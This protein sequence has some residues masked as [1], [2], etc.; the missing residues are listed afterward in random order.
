MVFAVDMRNEVGI[1]SMGDTCFAIPPHT[2][3]HTE[4]QVPL[5]IESFCQ[6]SLRVHFLFNPSG[7]IL[8]LK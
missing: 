8:E 2:K 7:L 6:E 5:R 1:T 4:C 3:W